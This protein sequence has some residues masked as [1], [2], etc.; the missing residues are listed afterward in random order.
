MANKTDFE[1]PIRI[2]DPAPDFQVPAANRD[3][4]IGLRDYKGRQ[5]VLIGLFRGL[6]CPFCR[7]QV[8]LMD[9]YSDRLAE[10]GVETVAVMN[11]EL[12]RAQAY[13]GR[14]KISMPLGVDPDWETHRRYGLPRSKITLG[15]TDWPTKVNPIGMLT[16]KINPSGELPEPVS[17][18]KVGDA[19]NRID[20]FE[21]TA[22]DKKIKSAHGLT[23][24]G[25]TLIDKDGIILWR[26]LEALTGVQ[27]I[28]KF[29]SADAIIAAVSEA[30][31]RG[32]S[33]RAPR[34]FGK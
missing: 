25:F 16:L 29:P 3:G 33:P 30:Q 12:N 28:G 18:I 7:R 9:G 5:S 15:K 10:L 24:A 22:V 1:D 6:H 20:G 26:W 23:G 2:G 27:D 31:R 4:D 8:V 14:L 21:P 19:V 11:T 17:A 34:P 32:F 13:Y